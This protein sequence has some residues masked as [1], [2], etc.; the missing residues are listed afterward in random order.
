MATINFGNTQI[1]NLNFTQLTLDLNSIARQLQIFITN[2]S[3]RHSISVQDIT[4]VKNNAVVTPTVVTL[5]FLI[6]QG[7]A[8]FDSLIYLGLPAGNRP[9]INEAPPDRV[10]QAKS[11][12]MLGRALF[13]QFFMIL[14]RG[15]IS[16]ATGTT[17]GSEVP[18][19]L[20]N[21]LNMREAPRVYADRLATFDLG[22]LD[23]G[24][25]R[26]IEFGPLGVEC[27]NRLGLG[28]AG[29]RWFNP[30]KLLPRPEPMT[31]AQAIAYDVVLSFIRAPLS[32]DVH[33]ATRDPNI[34]A[35]Y[36]PLNA[37]LQNFALD[38]FTDEQLN[39]LRDQRKIYGLPR[40]DI[41]IT[42]YRSWATMFHASQ[43][44]TILGH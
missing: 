42:N 33:P 10:I 5:E 19:F 22:L 29:Y 32:W 20:V 6:G 16:R 13:F 34:L 41:G 44:S 8:L 39:T 3:K 27:R 35:T 30:F 43:G 26:Y 28:V 40:R 12:D 14:T 17:V 2:G 1:G 36:G 4:I 24:W 23:P 25:V 37:N 15:S 11:P 9:R 7:N 31:D 18:A 38:I 21:I